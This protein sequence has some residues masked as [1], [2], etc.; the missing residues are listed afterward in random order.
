[1]QTYFPQPWWGGQTLNNWALLPWKSAWLCSLRIPTS[2]GCTHVPQVRIGDEVT[3]L[4]RTSEILGVTLNTR[5]TFGPHVHERLCRA[6][7]DGSYVMEAS[8]GSSWG[9]STE[10]L[11]GTCKGIMSP[12]LKH[13]SPIW[14][15]KVDSFYLDKI[16]IIQNI[17]L[18]IATDYHLNPAVSHI[19]AESLVLP[20]IE[21]LELC[22]QQ[23]FASAIQSSQCSHL[24]HFH[25]NLVYSAQYSR[26]RTNEPSEASES[27]LTITSPQ[28]SFSEVSWERAHIP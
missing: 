12:I 5:F 24:S 20:L 13:D 8:A 1:M 3:P 14:F 7:F 15:W 10:T 6:S 2:P 25:P 26:S 21:H 18:W 16:E 19:R 9:F 17:A 23:F 11:V 22:S 27:E 28:L 4:N